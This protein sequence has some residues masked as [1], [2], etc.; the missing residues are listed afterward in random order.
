MELGKTLG[1]MTLV[2]AMAAV[3]IPPA[4]AQNAA[5]VRD[6]TTQPADA[7]I[8]HSGHQGGQ[9]SPEW[10]G[11]EMAQGDFNNDGKT[12]LAVSADFDTARGDTSP[13]RGFVYVYFGRGELLPSE[14]DDAERAADCRIYGEKFFGQF[15]TEIAVGDFDGDGYDDLAVSQIESYTINWGNVF[16]VSGAD[17]SAN[18]ELRMDEGQFITHILGRRN[19]AEKWLWVA[20]PRSSASALSRPS[21]APPGS[22]RRSSAIASRRWTR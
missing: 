4:R 15:G 5:I 11:R 9:N 19:A 16:L 13:G 7:R 17:I 10:F 8:R 22:P 20:N 1:A 3:A 18:A 14:I 21:P 2:I 12:D 6:L